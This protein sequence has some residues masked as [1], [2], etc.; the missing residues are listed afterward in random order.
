LVL[1]K[2]V[3]VSLCVFVRRLTGI[4]L[5]KVLLKDNEENIMVYPFILHLMKWKK[6][7]DN[8]QVSFQPVMCQHCNTL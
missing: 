5:L 1:S 4:I 6:A 7:G 8:P 3:V 2:K